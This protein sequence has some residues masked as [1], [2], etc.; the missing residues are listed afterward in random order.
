MSNFISTIGIFSDDCLWPTFCR[1]RGT[2]SRVGKF[3]S[4]IG[5][6]RGK[7][8]PSQTFSL[9]LRKIEI[10][11]TFLHFKLKSRGESGFSL[12]LP[13]VFSQKV[14]GKVNENS[15]LS[16]TFCLKVNM[17]KY[18]WSRY[19]VEVEE[20]L[21]SGS[22]FSSWQGNAI[23]T[24]LANAAWLAWKLFPW[25]QCSS[26]SS[27]PLSSAQLQLT[28]SPLSGKT[29]HWWTSTWQHSKNIPN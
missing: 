26:S 17:R 23:L 11:S 12:T 28:E 7:S 29:H 6:S 18:P 25:F 24:N 22:W 20:L 15:Q 1:D 14:S 3:L 10:Y 13:S 8:Q 4:E 5:E 16:P 9:K 2:L 27:L 21:K 19:F